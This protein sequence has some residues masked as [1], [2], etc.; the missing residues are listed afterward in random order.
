MTARGAKVCSGSYRRS[1]NWT[2]IHPQPPASTPVQDPTR[3][4][5]RLMSSLKR[6]AAGIVVIRCARCASMAYRALPARTALVNGV[7]TRYEVKMY[8]STPTPPPI[9][10]NQAELI[11]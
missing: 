3:I 5:R 2:A 6:D 4:R 10:T 7:A 11:L 8:R 9:S 1:A